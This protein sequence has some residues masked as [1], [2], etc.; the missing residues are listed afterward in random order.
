VRRIPLVLL[1]ALVL[2]LVAG[3]LILASTG[4]IPWDSVAAAIPTLTGGSTTPVP[5]DPLVAAPSPTVSP[6]PEPSASPSPAP[7]A[8]PSASP[9]GPHPAATWQVELP[10]FD[11]AVEA[12]RVKT[13]TPGIG[14]AVL[15][16]DGRLWIGSFGTADSSTGR[17]ITDDT[18]FAFAS[19]SKT[20]TAAITMQL[21]EE[22]LVGLDDPVAPL[23]P[24]AGL[25]P[26]MTL[27]ELLDHTSGLPDFFRVAGI[28]PALN[29]DQHRVWRADD[30]L[31]FSVK[32]RVAPE[33]FWRYSNTGYVYL[34]LIDQRLTG[35]PWAQLVRE[36]LLDPLQLR[37][38]FIQGVE[39]PPVPLARGHRVTGK[40]NAWRSTP[41]G[42]KDPLTPFTSVVTAAGSAG[43][44]AGSAAD[45]ARWTAALYGGD[46]LEPTSLAAA[47]ADASRTAK[48]KPRVAYGLG[49]QVVKYGT[50]VTW[51]HSGSFVGFKNQIRW[52][53]NQR[54]AIALLTDQSRVDTGS[55]MKTLVTMAAALPAPSAPDCTACR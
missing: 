55:L 33:T 23:L 12:W 44:V 34:G 7:S 49:V 36:R 35:Q 37:T 29:K 4:R 18:A 45:A 51:G 17:P 54:I 21:V 53:P 42:G 9:I 47:V 16:P 27:R 48:F 15:F 30:A 2:A 28:D 38:A 24:E 20:F 26:R 1:S 40:A 8:A 43:A 13:G 46:V 14:A 32:D 3:G 50:I 6:S 31:A 41:L 19:V 39:P 5:P 25:D 10:A 11:R 22:G 52:L